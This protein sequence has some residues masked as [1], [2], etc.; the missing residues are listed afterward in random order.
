MTLIYYTIIAISFLLYGIY[1]AIQLN[2]NELM[3][4]IDCC[5]KSNQFKSTFDSID[6]KTTNLIENYFK[7]R[8]LISR[9]VDE[10]I[11]QI[12]DLCLRDYVLVWYQKLVINCNQ[13]FETKLK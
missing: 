13:N 12:I 3:K 1:F 8:T 10:L 7:T 4:T 11:E 9:N 6:S 2:R 5:D